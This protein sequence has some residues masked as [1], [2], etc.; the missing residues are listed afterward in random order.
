MYT[1]SYSLNAKG[2]NSPQPSEDLAE[3]SGEETA[4]QTLLHLIVI[5]YPLLKA[6]HQCKHCNS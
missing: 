6:L 1:V 5:L 3:V 2:N 4:A